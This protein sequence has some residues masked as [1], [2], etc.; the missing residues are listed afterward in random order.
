MENF[1][2]P[3]SL[4]DKV[5]VVTGASEG[6]G[7]A[8]GLAES[9]AELIVCS[10]RKAELKEVQAQIERKGRRDAPPLT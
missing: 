6:I 9:G 3:F 8:L 1:L 5:A 2:K 4:S 10:R 7:E